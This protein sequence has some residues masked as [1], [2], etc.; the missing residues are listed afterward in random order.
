VP[1]LRERP[2]PVEPTKSEGVEWADEHKQAIIDMVLTAR[3]QDELCSAASADARQC[4]EELCQQ[5]AAQLEELVVAFEGGGP[6]RDH[7]TTA[8]LDHA[9]R[10]VRVSLEP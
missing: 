7:I 5:D 1:P 2:T 3:Q 8:N 10:W 9:R 4:H 6:A